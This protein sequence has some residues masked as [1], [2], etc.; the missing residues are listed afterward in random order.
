MEPLDAFAASV[1]RLRHERELTQERLAELSDLHLTDIA[2][3]ET[4]RRDPSVKVVAKIAHGLKVPASAL[5]E[6]V[7]YQPKG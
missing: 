1:R 3:I 4:R 2:R 6:G 5:L 7:E